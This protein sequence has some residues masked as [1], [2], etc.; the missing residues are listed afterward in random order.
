MACFKLIKINFQIITY[1]T[2]YNHCTMGIVWSRHL[3]TIRSDHCQEIKKNNYM[4]D[5]GSKR[6][7]KHRCPLSNGVYYR[8]DWSDWNVI[9][10]F[11]LKLIFTQIFS[12]LTYI[13]HDLADWNLAHSLLFWC[14]I[15]LNNRRNDIKI[16]FKIY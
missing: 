6:V 11:Q 3:P 1:R 13:A 15:T 5:G 2:W 14:V 12:N 10:R 4:L 16:F 7:C 8:E 9:R